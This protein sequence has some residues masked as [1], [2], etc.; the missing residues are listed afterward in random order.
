MIMIIMIMMMIM[1]IMM[2]MKMTMGMTMGMTMMTMNVVSC[3][4]SELLA[5][6]LL[7]CSALKNA[8]RAKQFAQNDKGGLCKV[9][10]W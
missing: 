6:R 5:L 10:K 9:K 4:H 1:M 8:I 7:S 2:K 3:V